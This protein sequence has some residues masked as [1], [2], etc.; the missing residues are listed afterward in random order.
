MVEK[1]L[2]VKGFEGLYE[3]SNLGNVKSLK[4]TIHNNGNLYHKRERILKQNKS[5]GRHCTVILCKEGKTYSRLV[6]RLVAEAFIPNVEGKPVVDHIDTNPQNNRVDNLRWVTVQENCLNPLTRGHN[7]SSKMGHPYHGRPFTEDERRMIS[8]KL[9]GRPLTEEHKQ[10]LSQARKASP[11]AIES[12]R[13]N[14]KKAHEFNRGKHRSNETKQ[15]IE[16]KQIGA[17]KGKHWKLVDGKRV[18]Y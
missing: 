17:L 1:W 11:A 12:S 13:E 10:K 3:V 5:N 9:R 7:S 14:I 16:E 18:W 6:H 8:A 2:P 4:R 15:K